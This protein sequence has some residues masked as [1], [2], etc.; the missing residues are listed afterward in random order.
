MCVLSPI[1]AHP[2]PFV[3]FVSPV[4]KKSSSLSADDP[5]AMGRQW[6]ELNK[7][8]VKIKKTV[9]TKA[10]KGNAPSHTAE[11]LCKEPENDRTTRVIV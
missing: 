11:P 1:Y 4:E 9:D 6:V 10:S 3:F 2:G 5:L 7:H 8:R